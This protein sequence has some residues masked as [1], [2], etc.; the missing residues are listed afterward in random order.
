V[1]TIGKKATQFLLGPII[2]R[3]SLG[4]GAAALANAFTTLPAGAVAITINDTSETI[5]A[6]PG[7]GLSLT[8]ED[9]GVLGDASY[10]FEYL[11]AGNVPAPGVVQTFNVNWWEGAVGGTCAGLL[12][13]GGS[14]SV[15]CLSDT[16]S[17]TL[18]GHVGTD[19]NVSVDLSF[20]SDS[21]ENASGLSL[22]PTALANPNVNITEP[23]GFV[24]YSP[25][26]DLSVTIASDV[27]EPGTLTLLG[28]GLLGMGVLRRRRKA[29]A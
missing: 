7:L 23:R 6:T 26:S 27:P 18:T 10:H 12:P 1:T 4:V 2:K 14:G 20:L 24:T 16:L 17:I 19:S 9:I 8:Q 13:G 15:A 29:K 28:A 5:T 22:L 25:L 11:S 21:L 3:L